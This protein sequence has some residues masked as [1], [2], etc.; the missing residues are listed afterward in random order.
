[1]L[2][3]RLYSVVMSEVAGKIENHQL[4]NVFSAFQ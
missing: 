2:Q 1:M 3:A 4:W